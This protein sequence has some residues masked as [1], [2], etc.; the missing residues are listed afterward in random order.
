MARYHNESPYYDDYDP[1]KNYTAILALP[2]RVEQAREFT[3]LGSIQRDFLGRLG[4]SIYKSGAII[5]GCNL[6]VSGTNAKIQSGRMYLDGLVRII[7]ETQLQI[8]GVGTEI[9][10]AKIL[11]TI[12][13]ETDDSTLLD[14]AQGYENYSQPGAHRIKESVVFV[15]NDDS[16]T[17][18]YSLK[19]GSIINQAVDEQLDTITT[20]LARRTYDE[21]GNYKVEGL[22]M[23]NRNEIRDGHIILNLTQGKAY[24]QGY[25]VVK[26][27]ISTFALDYSQDSRAVSSEP[28][29]FQTRVTRYKINNYPVKSIDRVVCVLQVTDNI[30]RGNTVGGIDY[31][32]KNP[33][34]SVSSVSAGSKTYA[35]GVDYQLA[36]D[37]IDWSLSGQEPSIGTTYQVTYTYN[38]VMQIGSDINLYHDSTNNADY[39]DI[40][41]TSGIVNGSRITI[42]YKYYLARKDLVCLDKSGTIVVYKGKPDVYKLVEPPINQDPTK[43]IIGT[44]LIY[45]NSP[46]LEIANFNTNRITQYEIY[47]MLR[48]I[49]DMEYNQAISDLDK[50][51]I[52]GE[53]ATNLR[54]VFTDGFLGTTKADISNPEFDCSIDLDKQELILPFDT[55]I[56]RVS[57]SD[58]ASN[59]LKQLGQVVTSPYQEVEALS[60]PLATKAMLVN[61]YAVYNPMSLVQLNPSVDNWIDTSKITINKEITKTTSLARWWYHRG[62]WWAEA[63]R[64][65]YLDA[66]VN[67]NDQDGL[68]NKTGTNV[69]VTSDVVLDESIMYMRQINVAAAGHNFTPNADIHCLFND[70]KIPLTA[71]GSTRQSSSSGNIL[72][73]ADGS[74][75]CTFKVPSNTP[76]GTVNVVFQHANGKGSATYQAN[77]RKQ[78]IQDTVLTTKTIVSTYDPL[79]QTFQFS[80]DTILTKADLFFAAKDN[81]K[82]LICQVRNVVNGY[83]GQICYSEVEVLAKD[84]VVSSDSSKATTVQFSQPVYCKADEQ[85]CITVISDSN[86]YQMYVAE[87]GYRD[88]LTTNYVTSNPYLSGVLFSSSNAQTWTAHQTMDLKFKLYKAKYTGNGVIVFNEVTGTQIQKLLLAGQ[89]LDYKNNGITWYY[90]VVEGHWL[91]ID[92]Y[93][94]RELD[95]TTNKV[96]LKAE[97][98]ANN[99]TSPIVAAQCL[100][101]VSF[102]NK[103]QGTYISRLVS[104]DNAFTNIKVSAELHAPSGTSIR[105]YYQTDKVTSWTELTSAN[106][107]QISKVTDEFSRYSWEVPSITASKTYRVKIVMTTNNPVIQP[108]VR[109]LMNILKY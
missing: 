21:S 63:E 33:V 10:G 66:G 47:Q 69:S 28:K 22:S 27:T 100:N 23:M 55:N 99:N 89:V 88:L 67:A 90:S 25:E 78:I 105:F 3:Q 102:L 91:P 32:P 68:N 95:S 80:E 61:P 56:S 2:G 58:S 71:T 104:M 109:R 76:C 83:P 13:T 94:E 70:T 48:R 96:K 42:D 65:K 57:I 43:L 50:E 31:L 19:D 12:V 38:K 73:N 108:R 81:S 44:C 18:I 40:T 35:A 8:S 5:D 4:D 7:N 103:N 15:L 26:P 41:N 72:A 101:L 1:K 46:D 34:V 87:L 14:P 51:A 86:N 16:A 45:P 11:S 49:N 82:S 107:Q 77:G 62:A 37:G 17:P 85:Y 97:L 98:N 9:I 92:T 29:T 106:N 36:S 60:Q 52:D 20:T 39:L 54:G 6:V 59:K 53:A 75:N 30:T 79:A 84:V 74:F 24:I 93:V 64:Q